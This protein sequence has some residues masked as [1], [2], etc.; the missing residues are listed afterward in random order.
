MAKVS[1]V[2]LAGSVMA[3]VIIAAVSGQSIANDV[4][5]TSASDMPAAHC[6][7]YPYETRVIDRSTLYMQDQYGNGAL[8]KTKSPCLGAD[9]VV[10]LKAGGANICSRVDVEIKSQ[11][12]TSEVCRVA[13]VTPLSSDKAKTYAFADTNR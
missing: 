3:L 12:S 13:S 6:L 2:Y 5:G 7:G 11:A 1:R 8:V 9:A 10:A 4:R